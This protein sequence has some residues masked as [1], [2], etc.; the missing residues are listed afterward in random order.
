MKNISLA[1][2]ILFWI[3]ACL[4]QSVKPD[5]NS[6]QIKFFKNPKYYS[7]CEFLAEIQ[8]MGLTGHQNSYGQ[9]L[10]KIKNK[11]LRL[12]GNYIYLHLIQT[13]ERTTTMQGEL[14]QCPDEFVPQEKDMVQ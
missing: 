14:Y 6:H 8:S 1:I 13:D 5:P 4:S 7:Q 10:I 11:A 2:L 3:S 12:G 9:A